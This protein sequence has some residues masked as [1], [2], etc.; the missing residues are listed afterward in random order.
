MK[1]YY[2]NMTVIKSKKRKSRDQN[3]QQQRGSFI[4]SK[5]TPEVGKTEEDPVNAGRILS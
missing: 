5:T 3:E 2:E 4:R 1:V